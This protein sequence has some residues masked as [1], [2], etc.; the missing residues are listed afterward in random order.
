MTGVRPESSPCATRVHR[1]HAITAA[2]ADQQP[3]QQ[4]RPFAGRTS[5]RVPP[6]RRVLPQLL[7]VLHVSLPRD[8]ARMRTL[9]LHQ[10]P[11]RMARVRPHV[12]DLAVHEHR[13]RAPAAVRVHARIDGVR[14]H[15]VQPRDVEGLPLHREVALRRG[16]TCRTLK[17]RLAC[18]PHHRPRTRLDLAPVKDDAHGPLDCLVGIQL[19]ASLAPPVSRR[20]GQ[21]Q[22]SAAC[23]VLTGPLQA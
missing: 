1:P 18:P 4:G 8:V 20:G 14:Q 21:P 2:T 7:L 15:F 23:L 13:L 22:R 6:P 19:E 17:A 3:A 12:A 9:E 16:P 11:I 10:P 5:T